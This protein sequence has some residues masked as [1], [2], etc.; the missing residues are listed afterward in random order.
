VTVVAIG[1]DRRPCEAAGKGLRMY[2]FAVGQKGA[3]ADATTLH[4]RL[5]AMASAAGVGNVQ[6][7]Y[8]RS[9]IAGG[10]NCCSVL[11]PGVAVETRS[12][13][14]ALEN[15]RRV[16]AGIVF[17]VSFG[18][19]VLTSEIWQILPWSMASLT[20]KERSYRFFTFDVRRRGR[21]SGSRLV[22]CSGDKKTA[23]QQ[24]NK[25]AP[26]MNV[27]FCDDCSPLVF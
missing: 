2:A 15:S 8:S 18:M 25:N 13:F 10:K 20:L 27:M 26:P 17:S 21:P 1:A 11:I 9:R 3:I 7:I 19:K 5:V 6:S 16:V 23:S 22:L 24:D 12:P 14:G 4:D